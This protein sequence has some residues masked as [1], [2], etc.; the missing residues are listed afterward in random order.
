MIRRALCALA[1]VLASQAAVMDGGPVALGAGHS[2]ADIDQPLRVLASQQPAASVR[3]IVQARVAGD[4]ED[5]LM[6]SAAEIK[7]HLPQIGGIAAELRADQVEVLARRPGVTRVLLDPRMRSVEQP[8][9]PSEPTSV[10]PQ[11]VRAPDVWQTGR[12]GRG[13]AIAVLD[14][15]I[16]AN[17]DFGS[18]SRVVWSER[19]NKSASSNADQYGHGTWVAGIAAGQG[20]ASGG[21]YLGVAPQASIVNLKV[22]DDTGASYAS[23]VI[24]ALGWVATNHAAYNIRVVNLSLVSSMA[25]GYATSVLDA[26]V[27]M[28]WHAGVVVVVAAGNRGPDTV[29]Y[30]PANDPYVITV[31][32]VDDMGTPTRSDDGLAWFSSFGLTQAGGAKPD[33]LA[34]GRHIIG[35][36]ATTGARLAK[37]FPDKVIGMRYIQ[38]SGT[39]AAAPVVSGAV[40]LLLQARPDLT[41]DQVKWLLMR[42]AGAVSS[43]SSG[44]EVNLLAA[45]RYGEQVS[46][47]NLGLTPNQL[48]GLA[49]LSQRGQPT[50]SWDSVSWDSVSWDSVSWDS[51]SWDS[52]SWDSVSWDSV[53]W[54]SVS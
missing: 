33:L 16:Q 2:G 41:N 17:S 19:F 31:G 3:V 46:R 49:Y 6:R 32:A 15:G 28:V 18:P 47:A 24:H 13:I 4:A 45:V 48:V 30:A 53:S 50:V 51:V 38:L 29:R 14:S 40:A 23:D 27:E 20:T 8:D 10:F 35:P 54:D 21:R 37:A 25:E 5:A 42:T 44:G 7:S 26:A 52:V 34:P 11:T 1:L 9:A 12:T 39:S 36:L 22:S 43:P